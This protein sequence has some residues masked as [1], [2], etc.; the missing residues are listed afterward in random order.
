MGQKENCVYWGRIKMIKNLFKFTFSLLSLISTQ[1]LFAN[2]D[3]LWT[4]TFGGYCDDAGNSVQQTTDSGF[5]FTGFNW[6][7]SM[8]GSED[9]WVAKTDKDGNEQWEKF[10]G[11]SGTSLEG[12]TSVRQTM[13]GGYIILGYAYGYGYIPRDSWLI[14]LDSLGSTRWLEK[15]G[16]DHLGCSVKQTNDGGYIITGYI[17]ASSNDIWFIKTDAGGSMQWAKNFGGNNFE[18]GYSVQ[19]T[20][21]DG[22]IIVGETWPYGAGNSDIWLVKTDKYGNKQW[23]KTF[24]GTWYECGYSVQQ[25]NDK[26]YIIAGYT[27]QTDKNAWII[28]TDSAG[29]EEWDKTFGGANDDYANSIQQTSDNGYIF[30]GYTDS[31]GAGGGDVWIVKLNSIGNEEWD[32]TF[33]GT[34]MDLG[35]GIQKCIDGGYAIIAWKGGT[36]GEFDAWL[37]RIKGPAGV[38]EEES[39]IKSSELKVSPN[40]F[41]Q[42]TVIEFGSFRVSELKEAK[43][44]IYD[45]SGRLVR[46]FSLTTNYQQLTTVIT[47]DGTDNTG[48]KVESG[49]YFCTLVPPGRDKTTKKIVL[50]K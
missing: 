38:D 41:T 13:D 29:N 9:L 47:W 22:Y 3:T 32:E 28:K 40:P 5:I 12:G 20:N 21:D 42:T 15:F 17:V 45:L 7:H 2:P 11:N 16:T 25:T 6:S 48:K 46:S 34:S 4:R 24:G 39:K 31:Y 33:G 1:T 43:L 26:G 44:Q 18:C 35:T 27:W 19:Q 50:T 36:G 14:K 49:L 23:D 30:T 37:L 10:F 8:G